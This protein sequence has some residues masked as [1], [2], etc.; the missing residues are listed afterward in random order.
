IIPKDNKKDLE[1]IPNYVLKAL[2]FVYVEHMDQVLKVA[3]KNK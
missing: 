3:L 2:N 1:D